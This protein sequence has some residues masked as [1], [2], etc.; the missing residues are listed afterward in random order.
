M[1][2]QNNEENYI[3]AFF[4]DHVGRLLDI[5]AYD[6]KTFSNTCRLIELGWSAVMVEPSPS[7]FPKL[8]EQHGANPQVTLV[9]AAVSDHNGT[10]CFF[11]ARGDAISTLDPTHKIKWEHG[12]GVDFSPVQVATTTVADLFATHGLDFDFINLDVEGINWEIFRSMTFDRMPALRL[13]CV[14]HDG[15]INAMLHILQPLGFRE[16]ACNAENLIAG[17]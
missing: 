10:Q 9:Q 3:V 17:R 12:A 6:G 11:D 4:K 14:E 2:S 13:I 7:V 8:A 15:W 1:Y 5:G 16:I